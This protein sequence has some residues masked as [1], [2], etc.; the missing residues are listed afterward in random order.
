MF[1]MLGLLGSEIFLPCSRSDK[2]ILRREDIDF[3]VRSEMPLVMYFIRT[4]Q[5]HIVFLQVH[6]LD[7]SRHE[8]E[9]SLKEHKGDIVGAFQ[10]LMS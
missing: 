3:L 8:V 10:S 4:H 1:V 5:D 9:A 6:E 7:L 2:I